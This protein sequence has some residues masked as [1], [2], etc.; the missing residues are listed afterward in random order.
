MKVSESW[1]E[2]TAPYLWT[3]AEDPLIVHPNTSV[4]GKATH[5]NVTE[6][7]NVVLCDNGG[8][9]TTRGGKER[10]EKRKERDE[11]Y[12]EGKE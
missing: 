4:S 8:L 12:D 1:L 10:E 2:F 9:V 7:P 5:V 11:R 3:S 6:L